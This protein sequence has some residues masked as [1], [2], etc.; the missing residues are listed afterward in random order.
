MG[1][2]L[3]RPSPEESFRNWT[4]SVRWKIEILMKNGFTEDQAIE[5]L[6]VHVLGELE[7]ISD[8]INSNS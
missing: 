3:Y 5:L 2:N 7:N 6:K 4:I 1:V 8:A